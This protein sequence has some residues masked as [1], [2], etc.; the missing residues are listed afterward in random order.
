MLFAA[1]WRRYLDSVAAA[2][3]VQSPLS[4]L[5]LELSGY[6]VSAVQLHVYAADDLVRCGVDREGSR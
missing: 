5:F 6:Y 1:S 3:L 2:G 4:L